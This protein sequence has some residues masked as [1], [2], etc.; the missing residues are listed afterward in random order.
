MM[1][2][3]VGK[4]LLVPQMERAKKLLIRFVEQQL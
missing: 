3:A 1:I 4:R 2:K